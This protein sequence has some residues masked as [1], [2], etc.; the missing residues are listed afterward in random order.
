MCVGTA[1]YSD[2]EAKQ[3]LSRSSSFHRFSI[4][5]LCH[6]SSSISSFRLRIYTTF[7]AHS[8]I[9][10]FP[11]TSSSLVWPIGSGC[12]RSSFIPISSAYLCASFTRDRRPVRAAFSSNSRTSPI[13]GS[14][15]VHK[16]ITVLILVILY[17][18]SNDF[19]PCPPIVLGR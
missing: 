19:I 17:Y 2:I 15:F 7:L 1:F 16:C 11:I 6:F 18:A 14:G 9:F 12:C 13:V 3:S 8:P 4:S 5:F 10:C